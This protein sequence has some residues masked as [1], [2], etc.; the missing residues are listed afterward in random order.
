MFILVEAILSSG[1]RSFW[2]KSFHLVGIF[3]SGSH[4]S[5]LKSSLLMK[6]IPFNRSCSCQ[7]LVEVI[8]FIWNRSFQ[9]KSFHLVEAAFF[10]GNH[11]PF[12]LVETVLL[13]RSHSFQWKSFLLVEAYPFNRSCFSQW[14][15][16]HYL[17]SFLLVEAIPFSGS[18]FFQWKA[19]SFISFLWS[20]FLEFFSCNDPRFLEE[21]VRF[22]KGHSKLSRN[23]FSLEAFF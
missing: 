13:D 21:V 18:H 22:S 10:S 3:L 6:A 19:I 7:W 14:K 4:F 1:N 5:Y 11:K 12:Y 8:S 9:W 2:W 16:F 23:F 17:K 15:L 20:F